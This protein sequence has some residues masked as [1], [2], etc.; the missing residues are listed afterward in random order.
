MAFILKAI[1]LG[2]K[3]SL[4]IVVAMDLGDA[5]SVYVA[6]A[7]NIDSLWNFFITIHLAL[8]GG[9]FYFKDHLNYAVG[10]IIGIS[11]V[12]FAIIN[13]RA[14]YLVYKFL[15]ALTNDIATLSQQ[16]G[17]EHVSHFFRTIDYSDRAVIALIIHAVTAVV[18]L[19]ALIWLLISNRKKVVSQ[20]NLWLK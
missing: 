7:Q 14:K 19:V 5:L 11:Y 17:L 18:V 15:E 12:V 6:T 8:L 1:L 10:L 2:I 3:I 13:A 4:V 20:Q 9:Y 16:T